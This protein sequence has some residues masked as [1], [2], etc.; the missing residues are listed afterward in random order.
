[1]ATTPFTPTPEDRFTFGL[2]TVGWQ[3]R[4][5]CPVTW[6]ALKD[7]LR[8]DDDCEALGLLMTAAPL[9]RQRHVAYASCEEGLH[10][11]HVFCSVRKQG[12]PLP[13]ALPSAQQYLPGICNSCV[14]AGSAKERGTSAGESTGDTNIRRRR[15]SH[16]AH[17][18]RTIRTAN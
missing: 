17:H 1:M 12:R 2:W 9:E 8:G 7:V 13:D 4:D 6:A 10:R 15:R 5:P 14:S 18:R 16:D 3:G 11:R